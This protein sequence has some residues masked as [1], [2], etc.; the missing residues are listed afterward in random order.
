MAL[1]TGV[2]FAVAALFFWGFGDFLLQ[3]SI[4]K[5][6]DWES[7]FIIALVGTIILVPFVWHDLLSFA[8]QDDA[9]L[10]L[11]GVSA[12]YLIA[13]LFSYEALKK[14]KL[15]VVE[16]VGALEVPLAALL[17]FAL[18]SESASLLQTLVILSLLAGVVLV[19]LKS[20]HFKRSTWLEKGAIL[21]MISAAFLGV[22]DFLV[23]FASRVTNP[24][25]TVWFFNIFI[26]L[27]CFFYLISNN[28]IHSFM[29][30]FRSNRNL[31][32]SVC[33]LDNL[34]WVSFAI[35]MSLM[36]I[37][38]ATALSESYIVIAV[39]LGA[40]INKE[41]LMTHQKIGLV[42]AIA[43]AIYLGAIV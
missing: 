38:I 37:L 6:G 34:A 30:D 11:I 13:Q 16:P 10:L 18:I 1:E 19:S 22:T 36:P 15:S 5:I 31:M 42:L 12:V 33:V 24:L 17:A 2:V 28:R 41:L 3:R 40:F 25:I 8:L 32:V 35:A 4:R 9:F 20:H 7:I 14:G 23:G 26:T 29:K 27:V 39:L 43:S 21:G